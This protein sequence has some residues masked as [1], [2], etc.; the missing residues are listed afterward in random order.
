MPFRPLCS[1]RSMFRALG[2]YNF[3]QYNKNFKIELKVLQTNA[4]WYLE[5]KSRLALICQEQKCLKIWEI[6]M[7][8]LKE[9]KCLIIL[10]RPNAQVQWQQK[11]KIN[12]LAKS[13][14][15]CYDRIEFV[16]KSPTFGH[17]HRTRNILTIFVCKS[18]TFGHSY[19]T[20]NI[21]TR[22]CCGKPCNIY[23]LWVKLSIDSYDPFPKIV[24][25][26]PA[27]TL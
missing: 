27:G 6:W 18:P 21:S 22:F 20:S 19:S 24:Q 10:T 1:I 3:A 2:I 13:E 9:R 7:K 14:I 4:N 16:C 23:R 12:S 11:Y 15:Y 8:D 25:V 17:C 5:I 26:F